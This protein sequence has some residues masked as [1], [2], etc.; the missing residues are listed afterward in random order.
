MLPVLTVVQSL[1][2]VA[3]SGNTNELLINVKDTGDTIQELRFDYQ[4]EKIRDWLKAPDHVMNYTNAL[5]KRHPGTGAWFI[6]GQTFA[7]WQE[8]SDSF[9]WLHGI[10]GCGKTVLSST[11]VEHLSSVTTP[12]QV[13]LYFYFDFND[14]D[15][16]TLENMLRSLINQLYQEQP[17]TRDLLH[18][19]WKSATKDN[20]QVS[21][22]SLRH[23][24]LAMLSKS[25]DV[26]I[27]LD[28]LDEST[29]RRDLVV[30]LRNTVMAGSVTCRI[31]VTAR[32]EEDLESAF[33]RWM[34]PQDRISIQRDDVNEDIRAYVL[35]TVR[36]SE[37]LERWH[38]M[39]KVQ[40]EI[41]TELVDKADG[42]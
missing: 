20:Q 9:L 26:S 30:W 16:R 41:E 35:Q 32:R 24:L 17:N 33:Q 29:T 10:P 19:V 3:V 34:R 39:P 27:V 13:L 38:N 23:V 2:T 14:G 8:R 22:E 15:K 37:E 4:E 36:N 21:K 11:I 40:H 18:Q 31:L 28:A 12:D 25:N 7:N 42:M 1:T 5:E 6:D